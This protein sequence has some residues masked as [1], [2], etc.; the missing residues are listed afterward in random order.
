M[1]IV[2]ASR[3]L[4]L[5]MATGACAPGPGAQRRLLSADSVEEDAGPE[6]RRPACARSYFAEASAALVLGP[7]VAGRPCGVAPLGAGRPCGVA[8]KALAI[9]FSQASF[10]LASAG[11]LSRGV[12]ITYMFSVLPCSVHD[13][14]TRGELMGGNGQY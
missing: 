14:K 10:L 6:A 11:D 8:P 4:F 2:V 3:P 1:F 7:L 9:F 5:G 12:S 13:G